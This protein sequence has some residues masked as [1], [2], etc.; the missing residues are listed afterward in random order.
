MK[1]T[2]RGQPVSRTGLNKA[3]DILG[4]SPNDAAYIWT[5]I[6]VE[7]AGVTQ[8]F[9]FRIDKRPQILFE[10]HIFRQYT[11]GR[12]DAEAPDISGPA[13]NYGL[14]AQQ[15]DKLEKALTLCKKAKLGEEPALKAVSWGMGQV[16]G[17]NH[18]V[19]GFKTASLM[20]KA[21]VRS[22]DAQLSAMA[23]FLRGNDLARFLLNKDWASFARGYNGPNY[24]QN[25]YDV[26]LAEQYQRFSSGSL[27][28]LELRTAQVALLYLGFAPGKIDGITGPRTHNAIRNFRI[29]N[30]LPAGDDLD[31]ATYTLLC[32][33]A[34]IRG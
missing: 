10:R 13:G 28:N 2:G 27:I 32:R 33:K 30:G 12:F 16:M 11:N 7:T 34:K 15:Y 6:E 8:G 25:H 24:W 20:V 14:L 4:L 5:I 19:A 17:F 26:K 18:E 22:E 21:M 23:N 9:G 31:G 1:F 29:A 3:L